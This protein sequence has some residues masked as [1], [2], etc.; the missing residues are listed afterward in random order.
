[1]VSLSCRDL[2][3]LFQHQNDTSFQ[4]RIAKDGQDSKRVPKRRLVTLKTN[5]HDQWVAEDRRM[6]ATLHN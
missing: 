5:I 3:K 4:R 6:Y 2:N 1:M